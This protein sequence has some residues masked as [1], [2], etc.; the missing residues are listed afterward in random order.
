MR[1]GSLSGTLSPDAEAPEPQCSSGAQSE[2]GGQSI[3][4][5]LRGTK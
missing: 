4:Y 5:Q 2:P 3:S 1:P